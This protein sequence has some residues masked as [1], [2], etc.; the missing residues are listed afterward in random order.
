MSDMEYNPLGNSNSSFRV[1]SDILNA[2]V[3]YDFLYFAIHA[4]A[5]I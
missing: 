5:K 2:L 4:Y 1:G 3:T